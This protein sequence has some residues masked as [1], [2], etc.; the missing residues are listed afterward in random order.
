[1]PA[2]GEKLKAFC[3][4]CKST[5]WVSDFEEDSYFKITH[6]SI[7]IFC[8][9]AIRHEK[10]KNELMN[11]ILKL[12]RRIYDL[13]QNK[14]CNCDHKHNEKNNDKKL[15]KLEES[16]IRIEEKI[17]KNEHNNNGE[18]VIVNNKKP[19]RP[20][21]VD[22]TK[23]P[24]QN[25]YSVL[26][27]I[28]E[29]TILIG[30]SII[31]NQI[32]YFGQTNKKCR[33]F[34]C[35]PGSTIKNI[36]S[37]IKEL[38]LKNKDTAL[39]VHCGTNNL[40]TRNYGGT[41]KIMYEYEDMVKEIKSK[42]NNGIVVGILPRLKERYINLSKAIGINDRL[43]RICEKVDIDFI[44]PWEKFI[45]NKDY[46]APDGI[47]LSTKGKKIYGDFLN[48]S[49]YNSLER[50]KYASRNSPTDSGND[51]KRTHQREK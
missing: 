3:S 27:D 32:D 21:T 24:T 2:S 14:K 19:T 26:S 1:M 6:S 36:T 50:R 51:W 7:C 37:G 40:F 33:K 30:D 12:E 45:S 18:F 17:E 9:L 38:N 29:E 43:K 41:E 15:N 22:N 49:L 16:I 13:E 10:E 35:Y 31:R 11:T 47:H 46:F 4:K 39:I 8:K 48:Y 20:K 28:E 23:T 42:T 25:R 34:R 44:D 5:K